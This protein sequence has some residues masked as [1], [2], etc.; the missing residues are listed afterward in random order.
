MLNRYHPSNLQIKYT[1]PQK[2][3]W[4][5]FNISIVSLSKS[6]KPTRIMPEINVGLIWVFFCFFLSIIQKY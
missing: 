1:Y 3:Q 5:I 2:N 4:G 6:Y